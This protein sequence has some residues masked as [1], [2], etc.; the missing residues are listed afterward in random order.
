MATRGLCISAVRDVFS[1]A[2]GVAAREYAEACGSKLQTRVQLRTSHLGGRNT[3]LELAVGASANE[4]GHNPLRARVVTLS[5]HAETTWVGDY[6]ALPYL[7]LHECLAHGYCGVDIEDPDAES[8]KPFHEGWMDCVVACLLE[9]ALREDPGHFGQFAVAFLRETATVRGLRFNRS[10]RPGRPRDVD[11]WIRGERALHTFEELF[12]RALERS[13]KLGTIAME[14]IAREQVVAFSLALNASDVPHLERAAFYRAVN[15]HYSRTGKDLARKACEA[16][17]QV[18]DFI[19]D[20][21]DSGDFRILTRRV[22]S[23]R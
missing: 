13:R 20:F 14:A 9:P 21:I 23:I 17:P 6:L 7:A 5:F 11:A 4:D 1:F 8:S 12:L 10:P 18:L 22:V 3:E 16:R 19:D 2:Q 15:T